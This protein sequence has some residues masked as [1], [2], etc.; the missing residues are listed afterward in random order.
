MEKLVANQCF[1]D[2]Q[3]SYKKDVFVSV[4]NVQDSHLPSV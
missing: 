1:V 4:Q 2:I 3:F